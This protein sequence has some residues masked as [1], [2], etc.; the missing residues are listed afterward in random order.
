MLQLTRQKL[1]VRLMA[2]GASQAAARRACQVQLLA[3][4]VLQGSR[5]GCGARWILQVK[6]CFVG[7]WM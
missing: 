1:A 4:Q 7:R 5:T 3:S 2:C 6:A